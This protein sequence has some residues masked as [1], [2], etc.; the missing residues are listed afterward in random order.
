[1]DDLFPDASRIGGV[2][3]R[4]LQ[5]GVLL[6]DAFARRGMHGRLAS[7][8]CIVPGKSGMLKVKAKDT[9][10]SKCYI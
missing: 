4:R 10:L 5:P 2:V 8:Y 9:F 1:M 3:Q 6:L 7:G